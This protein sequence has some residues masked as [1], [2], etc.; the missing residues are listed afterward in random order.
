[1]LVQSQVQASSGDYSILVDAFSSV[2]SVPPELGHNS[3]AENKAISNLIK[4]MNVQIDANLAQDFAQIGQLTRL[5]AGTATNIAGSINALR[6]GNFALAASKLKRF[7]NTLSPQAVAIQKQLTGR[8]YTLAANRLF[9]GGNLRYGP[10][11]GPSASKTLAQNWLALQYG[12]KPLLHDIHGAFESLSIFNE[13]EDFVRAVTAVGTATSEGK[14]SYFLRNVSANGLR[15]RYFVNGKTKCKI[16]VR[17]KI[18]DPLKS[19]LAQTGFTNPVNLVWEILPFSFVVDWFLPVGPFLETLSS[20]DGLTFLEGS[21]TNFTREVAHSVVDY[22]GAAPLNPTVTMI[23][24]GD[25]S[26]ETVRLNRIRLA[27]FPKQSFPVL[28]NGLASVDHALNG[29]ALL[30]AAFTR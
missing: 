17:F 23:D 15:G 28:K 10:G 7:R 6:R 27:T 14:G 9:A 30:R 8:N 26:R 12:W 16:S 22:A 20:Y 25:Y 13:D 29:L 4:R 19:F 5:I 1:M 24:H 11:G 21:R 18:Q 2:Y 3:Q